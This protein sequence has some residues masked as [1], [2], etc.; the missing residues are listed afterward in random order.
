MEF[1]VQLFRA[2]ANRERIRILRLVSVLGEMNV[3]AI[4]QATR[5][6]LSLVSAHLRILSAAGLVWRRRSGRTVGYRPAERAGN[7]VTTAALRSIQSAFRSVHDRKPEVVA[8]ADA[9]DSPTESDVALFACFTA[10]THPRRLQIIRRVAQKDAASLT[11]LATG[12]S[13]CPRSCLSH[14]AKLERRGFIRRR[15][16]GHRTAYALCKGE[17]T[18]QRAL[19]E[20]VRAYLVTTGQ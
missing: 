16:T 6:E 5:L 19:L 13:M 10:F 4:A 8:N 17:G 18:M 9:T 11:E 1:I 14:L 7:P 20:A 15:V 12:L 3:S 2:L